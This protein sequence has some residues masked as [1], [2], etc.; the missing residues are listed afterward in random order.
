MSANGDQI[1][2]L[3]A[4]I[5]RLNRQRETLMGLPYGEPGKLSGIERIDTQIEDLERQVQNLENL[6]NQ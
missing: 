5:V 1:A 3:K 4:Q 6:R 2:G